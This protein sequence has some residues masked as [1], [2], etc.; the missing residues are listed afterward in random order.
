LIRENFDFVVASF[1]AIL[2]AGESWGMLLGLNHTVLILCLTQRVVSQFQRLTWKHIKAVPTIVTCDYRQVFAAET[3]KHPFL[4]A[5]F[6]C[7]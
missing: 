7:S 3:R 2:D 1:L 5:R 6:E 4:R